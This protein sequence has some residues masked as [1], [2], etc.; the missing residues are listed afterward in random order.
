[1][2]EYRFQVPNQILNFQSFEIS[3]K[4]L[5]LILISKDMTEA[6]LKIKNPHEK[7]RFTTLKSIQRRDTPLK[8][9]LL[10]FP[11]ISYSI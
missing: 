4:S 3:L 2:N 11:L 10:I 6:D 9:K 7:A 8:I 5:F 1:M